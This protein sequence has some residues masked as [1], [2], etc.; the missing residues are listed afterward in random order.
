MRH[1]GTL[2]AGALVLLGAMGG[3]CLGL[4][5]G[6]ARVAVRRLHHRVARV[7]L[8]VVVSMV[9][10]ATGAVLAGWLVLPIVQY[11]PD[12]VATVETGGTGVLWPFVVFASA[13]GGF[14]G[15]VLSILVQVWLRWRRARREREG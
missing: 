6:A 7:L 5:F 14:G 13:I 15:V 11:T 12:Y 4:L 8:L 10:A 9:L 2:R 3:A 1:S